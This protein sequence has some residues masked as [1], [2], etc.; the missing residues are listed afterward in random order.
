MKEQ[1]IAIPP[2]KD[3]IIKTTW[4]RL[5]FNKINCQIYRMI[6]SPCII[7]YIGKCVIYISETFSVLKVAECRATT[8]S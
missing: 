4:N 8:N 2:M 1:H 7:T 5:K 6:I 3:Q